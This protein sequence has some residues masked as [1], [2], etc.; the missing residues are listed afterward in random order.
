MQKRGRSM[1][2][3]DCHIQ[4]NFFLWYIAIFNAAWL[5]PRAV[6]TLTGRDECST[7][8]KVHTN[9]NK[10]SDFPELKCL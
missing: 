5:T 6:W 8:E 3:V 4:W 9:K 10:E 1:Y 2:F 7:Y